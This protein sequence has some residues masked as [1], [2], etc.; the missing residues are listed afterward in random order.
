MRMKI[1]G[2]IIIISLLSCDNR[3]KMDPADKTSDS[4]ITEESDSIIEKNDSII[5]EE[6]K[7][8]TDSFTVVYRQPVNGFHAKAVIK[9]DKYNINQADITFTKNG[10]SFTLHTTSFAD[11]T[12]NHGGWG[13][14]DGRNSN[15]MKKYRYKVIKTDYHATNDNRGNMLSDTPFFF[16]DMDFDGTKEL[17]I[18]HYSIAVKNHDEYDI[19]RMVED[20]PVLIDYAPYKTDF[21]MTD[22]PE[23][24]YK[25]KTIDCPYPEGTIKWEGHNIY[26]VSKKRKDTVVVNGRKHLFNHIELIRE[27]K[28]D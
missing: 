19:Y 10:K 12:F 17:V 8:S 1:F 5:I 22:Y 27:I 20:K 25:K 21:R 2:S 16:K 3:V 15:I 7:T 28:F 13:M 26:G 9:A 11:S 24:D 14:D 18:V 4:I 6:E 23:F